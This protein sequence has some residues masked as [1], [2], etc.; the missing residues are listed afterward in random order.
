[1]PASS[2]S[3]PFADASRGERLQ[4]VLSDAGVGSRRACEQLI[5]AGEVTVNGHLVAELPAWV[6]PERDRI[7]VQGKVVAEPERRVYVLLNKP[8][9][10][11]STLKDE[12][13]ADRRT[14]GE[15]VDHPLASHLFPVGRLDYDT[16]GLVLMTNDGELANR[17]T[18]PRY[19][20][21]KTYR[22]VVRGA[23]DEDAV[24]AL[25]DGIYLAERK[26]GQTVGAK[27][28][29]RV[30]ISL[31][32]QDRAN[33]TLELTLREGRNRQ[34]RRMMAA[35]GYPVRKLERVGMGPIQLKGVAR[36]AWRELTRDEVRLLKKAAADGGD[37]GSGVPDKKKSRS[38]KKE[39]APERKPVGR[40][41]APVVEEPAEPA[42]PRIKRRTM[43][44]AI[45][46]AGKK[47]TGRAPSKRAGEP[48]LDAEHPK[49][50]G[51]SK[52]APKRG[53]SEPA[54]TKQTGTKAGGAKKP[55]ARKPGGGGPASKPG[56]RGG[57][58]PTGPGTKGRGSGAKRGRG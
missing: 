52:A 47:E 13:G 42:G 8:P 40:G 2:P 44:N 6:D 25:E 50:A 39:A 55:D 43:K 14:V 18:H 24:K 5:E 15:L 27:R 9:R 22:V 41:R 31:I 10:T 35:V 54:R 7:V 28:T 37:A 36:G 3:H 49:S 58:R 17:L 20:V 12:P 23:L 4:R 1:M 33:T 11:L 21:P 16:V 32:H 51:G 34:V 38:R 26:A 53:H 19:G 29:S 57:G 45:N 48:A 46:K 30:E 56:S